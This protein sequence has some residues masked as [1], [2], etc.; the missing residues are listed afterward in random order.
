[1]CRPLGSPAHEMTMESALRTPSLFTLPQELK[2]RI[3][4]DL[5]YHD[6]VNL[7]QVCRAAAKALVSY[8]W[9][10]AMRAK[11]KAAMLAEE[12][13]DYDHR[14]LL[15]SCFVSYARTFPQECYL[16]GSAEGTT[17]D[18]ALNNIHANYITKATRL[19]CYACLR[20][21]PRE[22]FTDAQ[23]MGSRSLGHKDAQQRFCKACGVQKRIWDKGTLIKDGKQTRVVCRGCHSFQ[24]ASSEPGLK[25]AGVCSAQCMER[26]AAASISEREQ[27]RRLEDPSSSVTASPEP[28]EGESTS[29]RADRCTRCW[30]KNHTIN[31]ADGGM[32]LHLCFSCERMA[33]FIGENHL[34]WDPF[35]CHKPPA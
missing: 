23:A 25:H 31:P 15:F 4:S 2:D 3:L 18:D 28:V 17:N 19:N 13:A 33:L 34:P 16:E 14:E 26:A 20:S 9:L 22:C 1:M 32:G 11:L 24:T 30:M 5:E 7:R 10:K 8:P 27:G 35:I 6:L 12:R 29:T 21:L